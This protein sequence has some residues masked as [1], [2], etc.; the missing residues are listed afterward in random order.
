MAEP[1]RIRF[2]MCVNDYDGYGQHTGKLHS[3]R[4]ETPEGDLYL[5]CT[6]REITCRKLDDSH[7][8]LGRRKFPILSYGC[9]IGNMM[10]DGAEVSADVA[11]ALFDVLRE[12][13]NYAP[14]N[15]TS[16]LWDVW[17]VGNKLILEDD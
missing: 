7:I 1:G 5:A 10:W 13:G 8:R 9:Y 14:E 12:D 11:N 3:C 17:E 2:E 16:I 6:G 4:F 15:G